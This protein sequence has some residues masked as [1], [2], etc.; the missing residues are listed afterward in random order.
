[1]TSERTGRRSV[2]AIYLPS[3]GAQQGMEKWIST[4]GPLESLLST[5][6]LLTASISLR[7]QPWRCLTDE[8]QLP[9]GGLG[10]VW[11]S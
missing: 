1:M 6:E 4:V 3:F 7:L 2:L 11:G 5:R 8:V 10:M 9:F